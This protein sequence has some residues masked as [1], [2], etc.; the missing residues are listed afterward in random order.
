MKSVALVVFPGFQILDLVAVSVFELANKIAP[1]PL[2]DIHVVSEHGGVVRSSS[3]ATVETQDYRAQDWD[4]VVIGG[5][6]DL[7]PSSPRLRAFLREA[8]GRS[9]RG[10]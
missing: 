10:G 2:Y 6:L 5:S 1:R 3:G 7:A 9:R 8:L 4:T